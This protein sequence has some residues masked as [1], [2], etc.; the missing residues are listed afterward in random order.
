MNS[1]D[2][3]WQNKTYSAPIDYLI[4]GQ[5][6]E[7][8]IRQANI[9]V[10]YD[11]GKINEDTFRYLQ[12]VPK[13]EREITIGKMQL[14]DKTLSEAL[15][16]GIENA[17][18]VLFQILGLNSTNVLSIK[19]DAI[20]VM[21]TPM[22][23]NYPPIIQIGNNVAFVMKNQYRSYYKLTRHAEVFYNYDPI[24]SNEGIDIKGLGDYSISMHKDYI[25]K[26]FMDIFYIALTQGPQ[27]ALKQSSQLYKYYIEKRLD[28]NCYRRLDSNALFDLRSPSQWASFRADY[29]TEGMEYM[30]DIGYNAQ[31]INRLG[32]FYMNAIMQQSK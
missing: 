14:Q 4:D 32:R 31:I 25:L 27:A 6:Y 21:A 3:L 2:N 29:L 1:S 26:H 19:N 8:D 16:Q 9:S 23:A 28:I 18:K 12:S 17:R 11:M 5:I 10:L 13:M 20:F 24:S 7:F 15:N 22:L 30:V